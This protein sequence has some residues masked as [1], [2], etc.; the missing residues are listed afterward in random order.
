MTSSLTGPQL[1]LPA[2]HDQGFLNLENVTVV[3]DKI[4]EV[5]DLETFTLSFST[6][7]MSLTRWALKTRTAFGRFLGST[8]CLSRD[9]PIAPPTALFPLPMPCTRPY[10]VGPDDPGRADIEVAVDRG[11]HVVICALNFMYWSQASPPL[12]LIR[13][14]PNK[15]QSDAIARLRLLLKACDCSS[16][17]PV[18]ASG[19]K[20]L[21]LMARLQELALAAEQLGLTSSP[22][23]EVPAS[24]KVP[25]DNSAHPQLSPFANLNP[26]RLKISGRGQWDA[27]NFIEPEFFMAF[28]EPQVIELQQ[29]VFDRGIPNFEV[30]KAETVMRLFK[31]W[32]D[33]GLLVLH[34]RAE[35]TT[36]D[37]GRV[38]I[39]NAY[40]SA[41]HDRQIGDRRE[42]N[43]WEGRIPGPSSALPTGPLIGRLVVPP[44]HGLKICVT[45]RS[46]YYHQIKVSFERSRTNAVWPPMQLQD[47]IGL[48]AY[49]EYCKRCSLERKPKDRTVHGDDLSGHRPAIF[50]LDPTTEVFG[51]FGAILQGDHLGVEFGISAHVG[52]LQDAGLLQDKGR[53][54][55]NALTRPT[56][57][58]EG[59][60]IDDYFCLAPVPQDQLVQQGEESN[61]AARLAFQTAKKAYEV[62]GVAGS[63]E[64]DVIEQNRATV[65]G[66]EVDSRPELVEQ[67]LLPV[68][69]PSAKRLALSW[70]AAKA[71][72][73]SCTSD[74]L[75][76][77]LLGALVS[78]FCFRKCSMSFLVEIFKVIPASELNTQSPQMRDL[79]RPAAEEL[80]ISAILLPIVSTNVQAPFHDFLY[81][82]D[83]SNEKGA[84]CEAA[85]SQN[86]A[87]PLWLSGDFKGGH[88]FLDSWQK[89]VLSSCD[90]WEDTEFLEDTAD[91]FEDSQLP[92]ASPH[93]P[94]AQRFDF[95]EVCGGSGVVSEQMAELG[96][97]VGPII[98]LTYSGHYNLVDM[99]A[100]EWLIFLVQNRRLRSLALEP[101]CTTFSP[102]AYPPCRSYKVPRGFCQ[103][104]GKVWFGNRLAFAC[105]AIFLAAIHALVM[106]LLETP[107]RSKM[108]WLQEWKWLLG[109][110]SVEEN[111]T[112]SCSF[113]S[114]FQKEFR[115]L[116]CHMKAA[117]IC[118]PCTR[119]HQHVRIQGQLTKGSSVYCPGLA[120]ALAVLFG[121][122]LEAEKQF[123]NK[124]AL[125]SEGLESP[126]VNELMKSCEW[127]VG[128]S[129]K[130]S[131]R[132][133]I[134][135]LEMA[136]ALRVVK[137]A[138][139]RGGGRVVL[140]LDSNVATRAI[141]K[142][143][144]SARALSALLR[145]I[146][147]ICLGFG[148]YLSVLF[149]PTRLNCADDPTRSVPLRPKR[150]GPSFLQLLDFDGFFKL[151][152]LPRLRRWISNWVC[153]F[154]GLATRHELR[155][156]SLQIHSPRFRSPLP[157]VDF[158][159]HILDFDATL[160]FPGEGPVGVVG[161]VLCL[162]GAGFVGSC[163]GME[164]RNADD[165]LRA[166]RRA[167][168]PLH[169]GR[170]VLPVTRTNR[171]KLLHQFDQWLLLRGTSLEIQLS[172]ATHEPEKIVGFLTEYGRELYQSGRPYN[173][174]AETVNA[175]GSAKP[176]IRRL[177]TGAWDLAFSWLH[178]EPGSHHT[179]CPYQV[180]LALLSTAIYWGW[181]AVAGAI[182]LSWGAVCRIGE[183]LQAFRKDLILPA[184]VYFSNAA[185][186]LKVLEPK[187]RYK[188]ARHQMSR[189][190]YEDLVELVSCA[191][192]HL[193]NEGKLW[194]H[195][196]QLLRTRFRQLLAAVGLPS[197]PVGHE[198]PLDLGSLRA[199]GATHLLMVTEDS[200]LVRRRGRWLGYRTMQ[201]YI[202]EIAS[203]VFFPRLPDGVKANI[204]KLAY[205][206][207]EL[208]SKM[209]IFKAAGIPEAAWYYLLSKETDGNDGRN[210]PGRATAA[211]AAK[212]ERNQRT[213]RQRKSE[214]SNWQQ[215]RHEH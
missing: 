96:F 40:K 13:R 29:P 151:A 201:I 206:F 136:S 175:I 129:W 164:P 160:G 142:G 124:H 212:C 177:L 180:L 57:V 146:A 35:I 200:E 54:V 190:D 66:A 2:G 209:K 119:D 23:S 69:A 14:Q 49:D 181:P 93:R 152:E 144:S 158:Y 43:A 133:H 3:E 68:G 135:V 192:C 98:D 53:L 34:P 60:C 48:K 38:K 83:A 25:V 213:E 208:L 37:K 179:A 186:F 82:S 52:L 214:L 31:R 106:A 128:S 58:Y 46:D 145:K 189:L 123:A 39:F 193:P 194:P 15:V 17:I 188:S 176:T 67:G 140:L 10:A 11:L 1:G 137:V 170:P 197:R 171:E 76:S 61:S 22:Y 161:I 7:C 198:R 100:V 155:L 75:H 118:R 5:K 211:K 166:E 163:H 149:C 72:Q 73:L 139:A 131:G 141:A 86:V 85:I 8:L 65:V 30:D 195:S 196:A 6:W 202:Q 47:F 4:P 165:R 36:G 143:R 153:L 88:V 103:S 21:Q 56:S 102:A 70:I 105:L 71:A 154:L 121:K 90:D 210:F 20:N 78:A 24:I 111:Y 116:T 45:D 18:A 187:T 113:G 51:S 87:H 62:H 33:L 117:T 63:D 99:R 115:F 27:A 41:V 97:V 184:D 107:R 94:L 168:A 178:R 91:Q 74:A 127:S 112:A 104:S 138:A 174:Y 79:P 80:M 205:A 101:P 50:S 191:F 42:R 182:A 26:E 44:H 126:F 147:V 167:V 95:I 183:V 110:P 156:G 114:P 12:D 55:A 203:T 92:A 185:V 215:L 64:K 159:H 172:R 9:G 120:R 207:P 84:Y 132:S 108:A 122:H 134:N 28:Q 77:S 173:H 150:G 81:A 169:S 59:L 89:Q 109:F 162:I 19:R 199:G 32:D 148:V 157:P 125:R 204:I 130:W 16:P